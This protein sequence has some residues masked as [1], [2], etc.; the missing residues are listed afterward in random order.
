MASEWGR[1]ET[2]SDVQP[3]SW[4]VLVAGY[5]CDSK[6]G[7][8]SQYNRATWNLSGELLPI[9]VEVTA[10]ME[11]VL[12]SRGDQYPARDI[13]SEQLQIATTP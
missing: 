1:N 12:T 10:G 13:L 6:H 4:D 8:C 2:D 5:E 3:G 7:H 11:Q 9:T